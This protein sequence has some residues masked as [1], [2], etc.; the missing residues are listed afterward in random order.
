MI[1]GEFIETIF[2]AASIQR[3]N[4]QIK[5]VEFSELDK[6]A[7]KMCIAWLLGH[8]HNSQNVEKVNWPVLIKQGIFQF[9]QR[10]VLTDLKSPV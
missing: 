4:D 1:K 9:L 7:H 10:T 5:V 2:Q 3:W 8:Y 6:H